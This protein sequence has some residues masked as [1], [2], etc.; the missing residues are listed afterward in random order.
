MADPTTS[1]AVFAKQVLKQ[2]LWRHQRLAAE[3]DAFITVIAAARRTGKSM[4]TEPRELRKFIRGMEL[5][6]GRGT[7]YKW[8]SFSDPAVKKIIAAW[9]KAHAKEV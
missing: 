2:P 4:G 8:P 3:S 1:A 6:V 5:G 9:T 7:A